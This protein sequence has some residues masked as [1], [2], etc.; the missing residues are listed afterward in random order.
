MSRDGTRNSGFHGDEQSKEAV[1]QA[2]I[3][4]PLAVGEGIKERSWVAF[5]NV[6]EQAKKSAQIMWQCRVQVPVN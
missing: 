1:G 6:Q 5:G 2:G 3:R 4:K